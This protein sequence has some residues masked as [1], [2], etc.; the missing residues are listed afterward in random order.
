M[1][2]MVGSQFYHLNLDEYPRQSLSDY[3]LNFDALWVC[4]RERDLG[5]YRI[6]LISIEFNSI[7]AAYSNKSTK[8]SKQSLG[9]S[10]DR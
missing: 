3:P 6:L 9:T 5:S 10:I 1:T 7:S 4:V 8:K 2:K